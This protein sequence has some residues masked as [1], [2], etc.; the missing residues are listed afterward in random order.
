MLP[1]ARVAEGVAETYWTVSVARI[2]VPPW[3]RTLRTTA[4]VV[5]L[6]REGNMNRSETELPGQMGT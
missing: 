6:N 5:Q 4:S 3:G 2:I 1:A